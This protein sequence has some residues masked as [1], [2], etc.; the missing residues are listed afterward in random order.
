VTLGIALCLASSIGCAPSV[1]S[2]P[3]RTKNN[4]ALDTNLTA[5]PEE[6]PDPAEIAIGERLFLET[7]FAQY[8]AAH[9]KHINAPL[10]T[11]DPILDKSVTLST[12]LPGP[13]AGRSINCAACHLV[14]QH[15]DA[16]G[17]RAYNDFAQ[18]SPIPARDD[19]ALST[20]RNS[21][22]L[23]GASLSRSAG[24][25]LHFDGEFATSADLVIATVTSRN[26]GW[27]PNEHDR[28]IAHIAKVIRQ[29]N[30][31]GELAKEFGGSYTKVLG[32]IDPGLPAKFVLPAEYRIDV[33]ES[34]DQ[35]IIDAVARLIVAYMN[36]LKF[37]QASPYDAY[38]KA[39][40][41]PPMPDKGENDIAYG[42]RLLKLIDSGSKFTYIKPGGKNQ[43]KLHKQKFAFG[44]EELAGLKIFLREPS[45]GDSSV[46]GIGNCIACHTPPH[47]TDFA[48]HNT[49]VTQKEYN[50]VHGKGTFA[51]LNIPDL[52]AR[53]GDHDSFLP[54]TANHPDATGPYRRIPS[55]ADPKHTDLGVWN[56]FAN[57]DFPA[58][59]KTIRKLLVS[60]DVNR[61]EAVTDNKLLNRSVATFKT[62]GLRDLGHSNPFMHNGKFVTAED[63]MSFYKEISQ[64]ARD[65]EIRNHDPRIEGIKLSEEDAK[66]LSAFI[67]SLNEDYE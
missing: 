30:G 62:P 13:F 47:F 3:T 61:S 34:S 48:V 27:L 5:E 43:F 31:V 9:S 59:Q 54:P 57:P 64:Q 41:F 23:V 12:E 18:R 60:I 36:D 37:E 51:K 1:R 20:P 35:Q 58:P 32:G 49:G 28:A 11:G 15:K 56:I 21:P 39:N 26:Y 53:N 14:D 4:S 22:Q 55:R 45:A 16:A 42:R 10:P 24:L 65:G 25:L 7:R 66:R 38:L 29:D 19:G 33:N 6:E 50:D 40:S 8:F 67:R 2:A 17:M 44:Q 46:S 52:Q 63:V